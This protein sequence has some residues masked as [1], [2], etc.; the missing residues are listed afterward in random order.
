MRAGC[1]G[2]GGDHGGVVNGGVEGRDVVG[3]YPGS[4]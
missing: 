3:S 1:S 4:C 2:D